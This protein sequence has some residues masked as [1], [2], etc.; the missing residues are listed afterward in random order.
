MGSR[1]AVVRCPLV[2]SL[3]GPGRL[4]YGRRS[5]GGQAGKNETGLDHY[6]VRRYLTRYRHATLSM[7]ALAFARRPTRRA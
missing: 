7:L 6:Q 5:R 1:P 3:A 4:P 2:P